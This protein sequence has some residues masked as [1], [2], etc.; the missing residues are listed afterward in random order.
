[1]LTLQLSNQPRLVVFVV[2]R[3]TLDIPALRCCELDMNWIS[4]L[5][6]S[7]QR[8]TKMER[9]CPLRCTNWALVLRAG[10]VPELH[11]VRTG[12]QKALEIVCHGLT[13]L[14]F[15]RGV[16]GDGNRN[17]F[18]EM[19]VGVNYGETSISAVGAA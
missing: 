11:G 12:L 6:I 15:G 18:R 16:D 14:V 7:V 1:M 19:R 4:V 13:L 8:S 3:S 17:L 9:N 5:V 10:K 2:I